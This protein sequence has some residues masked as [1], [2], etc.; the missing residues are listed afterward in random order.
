MSPALTNLVYLLAAVSFI[1]A[2]KGLSH[3]RTAVRGNLIG[4][5]GMLLAVVVTLF[6]KHIL[7]FTEIFAGLDRRH[8]DQ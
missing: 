5:V 1:L 3:P 2:F 8:R 6:D 4:A 7:G